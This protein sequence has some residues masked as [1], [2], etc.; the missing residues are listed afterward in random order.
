MATI[1][2]VAAQQYIVYLYNVL[3][4]LEVARKTTLTTEK[5]QGYFIHMHVCIDFFLKTPLTYVCIIKK[6]RGPQSLSRHPKDG[7]VLR[8]R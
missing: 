8:E 1:V 7:Q 4:E 3:L 6:G 2:A 5:E